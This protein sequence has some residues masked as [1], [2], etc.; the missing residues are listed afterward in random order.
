MT[1][2]LIF[3]SFLVGTV[4]GLTGVGGA[5]LMTP[6]LILFFHIPPTMAIGSDIVSAT[7]MKVV[8][9]YKHWKQQTV[10]LEIVKWLTFGS[11]PGSAVGIAV[12]WWAKIQGIKNLDKSLIHVLGFVIFAVAASSLAIMAIQFFAKDVKLPEPPK[13]DLKERSGQ[14]AT[15]AVGAILGAAVG[16]TSVGSG[17]LFALAMIAFFRLDPQKLV[18]TDIVQAA[19]LLIFTAVGHWSLG[20]VDWNLVLPIW[21]GTV[22]GVLVGAKLCTIMPKPVLRLA[23]YSILVTVGWQLI[24][25]A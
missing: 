6:L 7:L 19:I 14:I 25:K 11:I 10:D 8:G 13:F 21:A 23:L 4:V 20:N 9:G 12:L 3:A 5:A 2:T 16:L 22:P 17:S 18:G 1:L 15:I 24:N